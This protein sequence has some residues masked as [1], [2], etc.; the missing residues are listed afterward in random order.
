M[1][2]YNETVRDLLQGSAGDKNHELHRLKVREHPKEGPYVES[3]SGLGNLYNCCI[4]GG[5]NVVKREGENDDGVWE[6]GEGETTLK[7]KG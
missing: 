3:K 2:I 6:D 7:F 5:G 1:E 4:S